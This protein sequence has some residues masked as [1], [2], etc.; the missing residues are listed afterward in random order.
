MKGR[1]KNGTVP[2]PL[3]F[4][5]CHLPIYIEP[6]NVRG[7]FI[8]P[9]ITGF[10]DY[11][12]HDENLGFG[13]VFMSGIK[14]ARDFSFDY[15]VFIKPQLEE[16]NKDIPQIME[17]INYGF[18]IITISRVLENYSHVDIQNDKT[19]IISMLAEDLKTVTSYD[20]TDPLSELIA[21][22]VESIEHMELSEFDHGLMIQFW[23]QAA[24]FGLSYVELPEQSEGNNIFEELENYEDPIGYFLSLIESEK[25]LYHKGEIN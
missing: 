2:C 18:D 16:I 10:T 23:I 19:K 17:N 12:K 25:F 14:Y 20:L 3:E 13:A 7:P 22:K 4:L 5:P 21:I 8:E 6:V 1:T 15:V 11:I 24:F 9:V